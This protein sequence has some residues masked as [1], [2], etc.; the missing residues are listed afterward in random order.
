LPTG[1]P[2]DKVT[3]DDQI[4]FENALTSWLDW[5]DSLFSEP[6]NDSSWVEERI[7]YAFALS[8]PISTTVSATGELVLTASEYNGGHL[9][10]YAFEV[11]R[12]NLLGTSGQLN[13][14]H[15]LTVIP[16]PLR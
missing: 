7:E 11:D 16:T 9:D 13:G 2:F 15:S 1:E 4:V 14:S 10:W 5:Y 12:N 6:S 8:A 3:S